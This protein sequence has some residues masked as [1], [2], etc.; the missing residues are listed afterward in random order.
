MTTYLGEKAVGIGTV[1]AEMNV[2]KVI[3]DDK[4]IIGD[5]FTEPL[6]V[7]TLLFATSESVAASAEAVRTEF[8]NKLK[9]VDSA[10]DG[11]AEAIAGKQDELT[12]GE[13]IKIENNVISATGGGSSGSA[14]VVHDSTLTGSGTS[15]SPLGL[16]EAVKDEIADKAPKETVEALTTAVNG[17]YTDVSEIRTMIG[18]IETA[19]SEI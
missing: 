5:G 10:I 16:S 12:A 2:G 3:T 8:N 17:L 1:K 4:T 15:A 19:L 18:N 6:A 7:N 9:V 11:Q 13:G 14:N